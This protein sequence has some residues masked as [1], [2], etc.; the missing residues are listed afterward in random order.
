MLLQSWSVEN[1]LPWQEDNITIFKDLAAEFK[2]LLGCSRGGLLFK[3]KLSASCFSHHTNV[4][5]G[6][7]VPQVIL[8]LPTSAALSFRLA[9]KEVSVQ[10]TQALNNV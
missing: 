5:T 6:E 4:P 2:P 7:T 8:V 3:P 9:A 1:Y 10:S